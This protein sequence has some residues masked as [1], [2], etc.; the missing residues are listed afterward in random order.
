[1]PDYRVSI[2]SRG[3]TAEDKKDCWRKSVHEIGYDTIRDAILT[4]SQKL[5][6]VSLISRTEPTTK[7]GKT[8]KQKKTDMIRSIGKQCGECVESV[9]K[10]KRKATVKDLRE[11]KI[12]CL[13]LSRLF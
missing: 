5:T 4:C 7:S 12:L 8:E 10:E 9:L 11:R 13:S 6:R 2:A 1:M 3:K